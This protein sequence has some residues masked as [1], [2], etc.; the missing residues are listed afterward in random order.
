MFGKRLE[1]FRLFGF[2]VKVDASWLLIFVLV[3]WSLASGVFPEAYEGLTTEAYWM[4]GAAG[5][6]SLFVSIVFH[7]LAHSLVAQRFGMPITGITLFLFGG[8]AELG[9]EP[10]TPK[11]EFYTGLAGPLSSVFLGLLSLGAARFANFYGW[12]PPL[13]GL[14][15][16]VALMNLAL[17]AFNLFPGFPLDGGRILRGALWRWK[18]DLK[19]ATNIASQIGSGFGLA[20][21]VLGVFSVVAGNFVGGMWWFLIGMFIRGAAQTSYQ[22][23]LIR[24]VLKGHPVRQFMSR[25]AVTVS[26]ELTVDRFV[27]DFV[28]RHHHKMFPVAA[29]GT[30]LGCLDLRRV[31]DVPRDEWASHHVAEVMDACTPARSIAPDADATEA[32][33]RMS[34][35]G[36]RRLLVL[37]PDRHLEGV[38]SLSDLLQ[39]LALKLELG[40][41]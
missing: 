12:P 41:A 5:A 25:D 32:L 31:K 14:F 35:L 4:L 13:A 40:D 6:L 8:V 21:I 7:E 16:Y 10:P 20:L 2:S 3:M 33:K 24:E 22:H 39:L 28:Y 38:I 15:G 36:T 9:E 29:N 37:G 1:L 23:T 30:V 34:S 18:G 17:A 26:P 11:A 19:W 27:E